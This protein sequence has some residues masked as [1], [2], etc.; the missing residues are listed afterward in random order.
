MHDRALDQN[1]DLVA[2][3]DVAGNDVGVAALFPYALGDFLA[4][5]DL[6]A[7]DHHLGAEF[8]Q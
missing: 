3:R 5:I 8:C 7:R 2:A 6:A 1:I 4:G